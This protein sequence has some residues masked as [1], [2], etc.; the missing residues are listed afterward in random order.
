MKEIAM[1]DS[2]AAIQS[3]PPV[4]NQA[5]LQLAQTGLL[6]NTQQNRI[7]ENGFLQALPTNI[8][9]DFITTQP[10]FSD[11]LL[12]LNAQTIKI[13]N[14]INLEGANNNGKLN[15]QQLQEIAV[16]QADA[17]KLEEAAFISSNLPL[18]NSAATIDLSFKA[19]EIVI[20]ISNNLSVNPSEL[21]QAQLQEVA[22]IVA[23]FAN[24]AL[25]P[26]LLARIQVQLA[27]SRIVNPTQLSLSTLI[28]VQ[29]YLAGLQ[30]APNS[31]IQDSS[32]VS[33]EDSGRVN[34][35]SATDKVGAENIA[36]L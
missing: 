26:E 8:D 27:N 4:F 15:A 32:E 28:L 18:A 19:Q 23:P 33:Y 12:N 30:Q 7:D 10:D 34:P 9:N 17:L 25:T 14:E 11:G 22:N 24:E 6:V 1:A 29:S 13:F 21:T 3:R 2:S 16:L 31:T 36:I 20:G 35:V 5:A